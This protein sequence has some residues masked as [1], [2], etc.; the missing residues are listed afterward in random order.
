MTRYSEAG[1]GDGMPLLDRLPVEDIPPRA[2]GPLA[3]SHISHSVPSLR[4]RLLLPISPQALWSM[5]YLNL[6][7]DT[8][9]SPER[10][11]SLYR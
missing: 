4:E 2:L 6:G 10:G 11:E 3:A 1:G 8:I 9:W 7:L 5:L